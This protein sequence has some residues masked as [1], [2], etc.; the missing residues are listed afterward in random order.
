[1]KNTLYCILLSFLLV[2]VGCD[3]QKEDPMSGAISNLSD[4]LKKLDQEI[5]NSAKVT[6]GLVQT[7]IV[8]INELNGV[9]ASIVSSRNAI[10][11]EISELTVDDASTDSDRFQSILRKHLVLTDNVENALEKIATFRRAIK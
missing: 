2:G 3:N 4:A 1:M 10:K 6:N 9:A 5:L 7:S 8:T 11:D